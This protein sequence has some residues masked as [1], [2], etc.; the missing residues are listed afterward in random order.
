MPS[1]DD[2]AIA[3]RLKKIADLAADLNNQYRGNAVSWQI[4]S[5]EWNK[6]EKNYDAAKEASTSV[7]PEFSA[8]IHD[9]RLIAYKSAERTCNE[10]WQQVAEL[11][12]LLGEHSPTAVAA[13]RYVKLDEP[14]WHLRPVFYLWPE[15]ENEFREIYTDA[16]L[17]LRDL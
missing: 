14:P 10:R 7:D 9:Q 6:W 3:E 1:E 5:N 11:L 15:V 16:T 8:A 12:R 4:A 13:L 2:A 17:A